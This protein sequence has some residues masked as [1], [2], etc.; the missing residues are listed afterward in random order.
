MRPDF[1]AARKISWKS[2]KNWGRNRSTTELL[3]NTQ[4]DGKNWLE[5]LSIALDRQKYMHCTLFLYGWLLLPYIGPIHS[6]VT[7]IN[8]YAIQPL[9]CYNQRKSTYYTKN[10]RSNIKFQEFSRLSRWVG[11]LIEWVQA[12]AHN[13]DR[14]T[15]FVRDYPGELVPE[16]T[17]THPPSWSSSNLYQL[18]PSTRYHDP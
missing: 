7:R 4:T 18:L 11:T 17:L 2:V 6:W 5:G 9:Q 16:E 1:W 14:F 12:T 8:L 10:S 3:T 15:A 13:N